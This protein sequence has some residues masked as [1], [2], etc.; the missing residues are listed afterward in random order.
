M[1]TRRIATAARNESTVRVARSLSGEENGSAKCA[2][3]L[4]TTQAKTP[5]GTVGENFPHRRGRGHGAA[6]V[7]EPSAPSRPV[8]VVPNRHHHG[9]RRR[10]PRR[11]NGVGKFPGPFSGP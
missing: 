7:A 6:T 3:P 10:D 8:M 9:I 4:T 1:N 5:G 11:G 2:D